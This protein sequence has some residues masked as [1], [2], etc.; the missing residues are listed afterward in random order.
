MTGTR[1]Q[2][3]TVAAIV[4]T[5]VIPLGLA[6]LARPSTRSPAPST[7]QFNLADVVK[8]TF[9][10]PPTLVSPRLSLRAPPVSVPVIVEIPKIHV[11][12]HLLAVGM[13]RGGAMDAPEGGAN[14]HY[15]ADTFWYRGGSVPGAVGT[16]T[17]AGHI[18]DAFGRYAVFGHLA[19]LVR[20]DRILVHYTKSGITVKFRVTVVHT[21]TLAQ[22][23]SRNVLNLIYGLGPPR[24][25][26]AQRSPDGLAHL[27]LVTCAGSWDTNLATHNERLVVSAVRVE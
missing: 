15:W 10:T 20:G 23:N 4:A 24:G 19:S 3:I 9:T 27:S 25:L 11:R 26:K 7:G 8:R 22:A 14:S 5:T 13:T 18:D 21:Y 6:P 17:F 16:A 2:W 12:S 1:R